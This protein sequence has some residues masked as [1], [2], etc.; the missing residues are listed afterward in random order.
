MNLLYISFTGFT[1][2]PKYT[3]TFMRENTK[4]TSQKAQTLVKAGQPVTNLAG[5]P[6][7]T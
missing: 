4:N 2:Q 6:T 5:R 7:Q 1:V 3:I